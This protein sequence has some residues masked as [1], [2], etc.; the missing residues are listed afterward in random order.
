MPTNRSRVKRGQRADRGY[1]AL[2]EARHH[3]M[4]WGMQIYDHDIPAWLDDSEIEQCWQQ[5]KDRIMAEWMSKQNNAG[6]RPWAFW[7][8]EKGKNKM[9]S[10]S[11]F[12]HPNQ[13]EVLREMKELQDW[14]I[15]KLAEWSQT[16]TS[17]ATKQTIQEAK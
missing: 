7:I 5:H 13:E 17:A 11:S 14:E 8:Y 4:W 9:P 12:E 2:T 6:K 16:S 1:A 3:Y 10:T 15:N